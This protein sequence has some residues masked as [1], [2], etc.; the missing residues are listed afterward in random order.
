MSDENIIGVVGGMGPYA[1]LDLIRKIF[2]QTIARTDH[3]HVAVL[4]FS[5][6]SGI[7]Y[8]TAFILGKSPHNPA[9]MILKIIRKLEQAG[10]TV[11]GIPC[12]TAHAPQIIGVIENELRQGRDRI[13][14]VHMIEAVGKFIHASHIAVKCLG[15]LSTMRTA[16]AGTYQHS[17]GLRKYEVI[18]PI[19]KIEVDFVHKA[20]YDLELGIKA[21]SDP[22]TETAR[23]HLEHAIDHLIARGAKVI[24]MACT[25]I[26][27]AITEKSRNG[28]PLLDPARILARALLR[29][30]YPEKVKL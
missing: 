17:P 29:E 22:V 10:A 4:L 3:E 14:L 26:P 30:T 24:I 23:H 5:M 12:N 20:I 6:P 18:F 19:E 28:V 9:W 27:L 25:E 21:K 15:I 1:G 8:R 11:V 13:R 7:V 2:D 16:R